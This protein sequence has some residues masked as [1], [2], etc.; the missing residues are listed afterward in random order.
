MV[1][2]RVVTVRHKPRHT[3]CGDVYATFLI[4]LR[5]L[6]QACEWVLVT[7]SGPNGHQSIRTYIDGMM[8]GAACAQLLGGPG[9]GGAHEVGE[10]HHTVVYVSVTQ[11]LYLLLRA[12]VVTSATHG[13]T[14]LPL[15]HSAP[16]VPNLC[17]WHLRRPYLDHVYPP[18]H[19]KMR[20]RNRG[21][22]LLIQ[23]QSRPN[24]I[25]ERPCGCSAVPS[26][27]LVLLIGLPSALW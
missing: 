5:A 2:S 19:G 22:D 10:V 15:H 13:T 11:P 17:P 9:S 26:L 6:G 27:G 14:G 7:Q 18:F 16:F 8:T 23:S 3:R 25:D 1:G 4:F 20:H 21:L 24:L 12:S